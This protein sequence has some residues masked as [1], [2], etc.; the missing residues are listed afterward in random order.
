MRTY[1][2]NELRTHNA[3]MDDRTSYQTVIEVALENKDVTNHAFYPVQRT[4][5]TPCEVTVAS[6]LR[7]IFRKD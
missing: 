4:I 3:I 2:Y 6:E 5:L 7:L 1:T